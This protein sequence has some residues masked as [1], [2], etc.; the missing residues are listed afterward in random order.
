MLVVPKHLLTLM[1]IVLTAGLAG[2]VLLVF[3][4][5]GSR[6]NAEVIGVYK[7]WTAGT[8]KA[9]GSLVCNMWSQPQLSIGDYTKRG[10]VYAF[11]THFPAD[12][13][14][15]Q[16]SL[17]M[18]Y[19]VGPKEITVMVGRQYFVF[20]AEGENAY[21]RLEDTQRLIKA[22]RKGATMLV[23]S[24]S[25]RGTDTKDTFSLRGFT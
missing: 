20:D 8:Y 16:I 2:G 17:D 13:I 23:R 18:G 12:K 15:D 3:N 10:D 9:N 5:S 19:P 1:L 21:A 7:D 24:R 4:G 11:V 22:F 6:A 14:F 25:K